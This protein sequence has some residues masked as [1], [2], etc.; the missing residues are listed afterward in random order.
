MT[1]RIKV[2]NLD[3]SLAWEKQLSN[4]EFP[5]VKDFAKSRGCSSVIP[6]ILK[7]TR[8]N[9][10]T[11]FS[12]DFFF[13]VT[14]HYT[15]KMENTV[16]KIF[17]V[18]SSLALDMLTLPIRLLT[19]LPTVILH[20]TAKRHLLIK[21]LMAEGVNRKLLKSDHLKVRL[22]W[23]KICQFPTPQCKTKD[24]E[25]H[26][27]HIER[28]HWREEYLN[29]ILMPPY[30]GSDYVNSGIRTNSNRSILG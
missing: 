5:Q 17:I 25:Q 8:T 29:F 23:E 24:G 1:Y 14:L 2:Y 6:A 10:L 12:K 7:P 21:Y 19:L 28:K 16:R 20:A 4:E 13:P 15:I 27:P 22:E 9:N 26:I 30:E 3:S 18:L 11:N